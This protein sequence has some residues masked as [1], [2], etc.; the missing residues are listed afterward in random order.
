MIYFYLRTKDREDREV[1][2]Q[3]SEEISVYFT[4]VAH[5]A[6]TMPKLILNFYFAPSCIETEMQL[7]SAIEILSEGLKNRNDSLVFDVDP[8]KFKSRDMVMRVGDFMF[9]SNTGV[10][11]FYLQ[12]RWIIFDASHPECKTR[13]E[14]G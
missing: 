14:L 12:N 3:S 1:I 7:L 4:H 13:F 5:I 9:D 6:Y 11:Y 2:P 8:E 10:G